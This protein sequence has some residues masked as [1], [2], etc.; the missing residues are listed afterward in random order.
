MPQCPI[1]SDATA[2]LGVRGVSSLAAGVRG[3][4]PRKRLKV[5]MQYR[6]LWSLWSIFRSENALH[7]NIENL[8]IDVL[9]LGFI[10]SSLGLGVV[11]K[12]GVL[13]HCWDVEINITASS[14]SISSAVYCP[15]TL[16]EHLSFLPPKPRPLP[17][18]A[19]FRLAVGAR[20]PANDCIFSLSN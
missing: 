14:L 7:L 1:A 2:G 16:T 19:A 4:N 3:F 5:L 17:F 18:P 10:I 20:E 15:Y 13:A 12:L 9:S 11:S 6:A 8:E